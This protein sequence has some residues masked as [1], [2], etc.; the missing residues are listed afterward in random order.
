M[1]TLHGKK[2]YNPR[3]YNRTTHDDSH[4]LIRIHGITL[5]YDFASNILADS[6]HGKPVTFVIQRRMR[7]SLKACVLHHVLIFEH[8]VKTHEQQTACLDYTNFVS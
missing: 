4:D 1:Y 7:C 6:Y 3:K 5:F 8:D 2:R